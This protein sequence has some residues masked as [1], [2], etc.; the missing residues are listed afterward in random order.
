MKGWSTCLTHL[1][2]YGVVYSAGSIS[3][4]PQIHCHWLQV[5]P[6]ALPQIDSLMLALSELLAAIGSATCKDAVIF[7]FSSRSW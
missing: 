5:P 2:G 4:Q 6:S 3:V 1:Y 7:C